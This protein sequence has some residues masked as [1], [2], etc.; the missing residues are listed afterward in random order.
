MVKR[1]LVLKIVLALLITTVVGFGT[2]SAFASNNK[3]D[4]SFKVYGYWFNGKAPDGRY[5]E[6]DNVN[7]SW[8][9]RLEHSGEGSGTITTFWLENASSGNVTISKDVKQGNGPYYTNPYTS[10]NKT[11]VWL[12]AQNNNYNGD[13]YT[14]SGYWDEETW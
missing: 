8:K 13:S 14:V 10:A 11:T 1:K 5:R 6:T 7:N 9:V 12:T 2:S 3:I 4:Y